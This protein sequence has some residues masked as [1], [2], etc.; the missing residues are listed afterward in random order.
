MVISK[1]NFYEALN[2]EIFEINSEKID[3][4]DL[5]TFKRV[6]GNESTSTEKGIVYIFRSDRPVPRLKWE[7][8]VLYIGQ[9]SLTFKQRY[10]S[11]AKIFA[12]SSANRLKF[13][14]ILRD[15]GAIRITLAPFEFFGSSPAEAEGQLLW[16]Y[17]Q[18]HCE[19]PPLNYTKTKNRNDFL[20][21]PALATPRLKARNL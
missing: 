19:Y 15:Y 3:S 17:F 2:S 11:S 14:H 21:P 7:S 6:Y 13:E 12:N 20:V 10:L 8:D 16:W 5:A 1:E 4:I 18:N 9:T